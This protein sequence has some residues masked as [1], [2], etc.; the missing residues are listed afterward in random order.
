[1][2]NYNRS[3]YRPNTA[4]LRFKDYQIIDVQGQSPIIGG[5]PVLRPNPLEYR[6]GNASY[7]DI[8]TY[9]HGKL[10]REMTSQFSEKDIFSFLVSQS[11][12]TRIRQLAVN[13]CLQDVA[14]IR[15]NALELYATRIVTIN[16]VT[17]RVGQIANAMLALKRGRWKQFKRHLG[18]DKSLRRP[19]AH[20]FQDIPGLWLEYAFGWS[21]LVS[22]CY[23]ILN[24]TFEPPK[25]KVQKEYSEVIDR[26]FDDNDV[27]RVRLTGSCRVDIRATASC[28]VS[29]DVPALA[30][31][32][33]YGINNPAAVAWELIPWSFVVDW[34]IPVGDYIEQLGAT[35]GL[36]LTEQQVTVTQN[37]LMGYHLDLTNWLQFAGETS[38]TPIIP[39]TQSG[40]YKKRD[41]RPFTYKMIVDNPLDQ[42]IRRMS[43][44]LSLLSLAFTGKRSR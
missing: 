30:A 34:F 23:N 37:L 8:N 42:S 19:G 16:T 31:L 14:G 6:R 32:A 28:M 40:K 39:V 35:A 33:Q 38:P 43:Y 15:T 4:Y 7:A 22:D 17:K 1:M 10:Y 13:K 27:S 3:F 12:Y 5:S 11:D 20:K 25:M 36:L 21:P 44:A 41:I 18:L 9:R 26:S 29:V 2:K 24:K